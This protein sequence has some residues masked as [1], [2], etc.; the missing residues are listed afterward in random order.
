MNGRESRSAPAPSVGLAVR[1]FARRRIVMPRLSL[2]KRAFAVL[3]V[4]LFGGRALPAGAAG[5]QTAALARQ[6]VALWTQ[7]PVVAT[8]SGFDGDDG[9]TQWQAAYAADDLFAFG[10]VLHVVGRPAV[11]DSDGPRF[12]VAEYRAAF[13]DLTLTVDDLRVD[14]DRATVRWTLRGTSLGVFDG[15]APTGQPFTEEGNFVFRTAGDQ[16]VETWVDADTDAALRR[17]GAAPSITGSCDPASLDASGL[18]DGA[19]SDLGLDQFVAA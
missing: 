16:I 2:I 6:A 5:D 14:G 11:V 4:V 13:P 10:H 1:S 18:S 17:A 9:V 3:F 19:P 7:P 15:L 12:L 8:F